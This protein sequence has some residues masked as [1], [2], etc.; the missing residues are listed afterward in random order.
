MSLN[1]KVRGV[2]AAGGQ[3]AD[4]AALAQLYRCLDHEA[5]VAGALMADHHKGY[6]MPIGGVVA[7]DGYLSPSGVGFDIGC[8]NEAV[9]TD[10][11]VDDF[12]PDEWA[13]LADEIA[14]KISFGVGRVSNDRDAQDH[15][16][17]DNPL[18]AEVPPW[19]RKLRDQAREQ[20]STVGGGNH[21]VN[22]MADSRDRVWVCNHFG[23]RGL[24]HKVATGFLNLAGGDSYDASFKDDMDAPPRLIKAESPL[25]WEY[26]ASKELA[27]DYA[28]F[29]R[30]YVNDKVCN[31]LDVHVADRVN[32][33]HNDYWYEDGLYVVRKGATPMKLGQ[34]AYIGG[35]MTD[36]AAIVECV[37]D[38]P[39]SLNSAP[40]GSGRIMSRSQ[41][42]GNRKGTKKGVVTPAMMFDTVRYHG[43]E[44]RGGD[45]DESPFVYRDLDPVLAAHPGITTAHRL[46]P[47]IVCMAPSNTRDPHED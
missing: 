10:A 28:Y 22:V 27:S 8:G 43:V 40:H 34:R 33:H 44:L 15:A 30:Q 9:L 3:A 14:E 12:E 21:Y 1:D 19:V 25:G 38:L 46:R 39:E 17:H 29:A 24:G 35:S 45:L 23:S 5:A 36:G 32:V 4:G 31:I 20:F 13:Q 41:A 47:L 16:V 6:S 2:F 37:A 18:W 7:Y 42:K 26:H 11:Y